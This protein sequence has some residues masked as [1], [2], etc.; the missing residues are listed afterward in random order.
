MVEFA[1]NPVAAIEGTIGPLGRDQSSIQ[2][3]FNLPGEVGNA[4]LQPETSAISENYV[5]EEAWTEDEIATIMQALDGIEELI[6]VTFVRTTD[7][8]AADLDFVKNNNVESSTG[9]SRSFLVTENGETHRESTIV[10]NHTISSLSLWRSPWSGGYEIGTYG[11]QTLLTQIGGALGLGFPYNEG[12]GSEILRS[13]SPTEPFARGQDGLNDS[14]NS[15]MASGI[16]WDVYDTVNFQSGARGTMGAW[17]IAALQNIYGANENTNSEDNVYILT[18]NFVV[19]PS[20]YK[21]IYDTGGEDWIIAGSL[22]SPGLTVFSD[23]QID[24]RAATLD[25]DGETSGGPV[26][27]TFGAGNTVEQDGFTI[28]AGSIIEN[29]QGDYGDDTL[30]GN[31]HANILIGKNGDDLFLPGLGEDTLDGGDG[32][33]EYAG[34][35]AEL[36]GDT[37]LNITDNDRIFVYG[38]QYTDADL[39]VI[40]EGGVVKLIADTGAQGERLEIILGPDIGLAPSEYRLFTSPRGADTIITFAQTDDHSNTI[41]GATPFKASGI[42]SFADADEVLYG[43]IEEAGDV[44]VFDNFDVLFD[45][46]L[47][48]VLGAEAGGGTLQNPIIE[49]YDGMGNLEFSDAGSGPGGAAR[50]I[51]PEYPDPGLL[52]DPTDRYIFVR[53]ANGETGTYTLRGVNEDD[54]TDTLPESDF[55]VLDDTVE[56]YVD[57]APL[58]AELEA[59]GDVDVV[60]VTLAEGGLYVIDAKAEANRFGSKVDTKIELY[61]LAGNLLASDQDSGEGTDAQL[62]YT[63]QTSGSHYAFITSEGTAEAQQTGEYIADLRVVDDY[64]NSFQDAFILDTAGTKIN[65]ALEFGTDVDFFGALLVEG[66]TYTIRMENSGGDQLT[67][68]D[69]FLRERGSFEFDF[70]FSPS[71]EYTATTTG[72]HYFEF[73]KEFASGVRAYTLSVSGGPDIPVATNEDDTVLGTNNSELIYGYAGDDEIRGLNGAD[74][75]NG[76]DGN[77]LIDGG[78]DDDTITG[79]AGDDIFVMR[80]G[81]GDDIITDFEKSSGS[82]D[83]DKLDITAHDIAF[84]DIGFA[85][86]AD[87]LRIGLG[88]DSVLL[89]GSNLTA[90]DVSDFI[91][92]GVAQDPRSDFNADSTDDV[93]WRRDDGAVAIWEMADAGRVGTAGLGSLS[94]RWDA[95][96]LGDVNGDGTSDIIWRRDDGA[97]AVWTLDDS[98]RSDTNGLGSLGSNWQVAGAGDFN[99]DGT[100][101]ILWHRDNGAVAVWTL[102]DG[103]RAD[104]GGMGQLNTAWQ[105]G[106]VGDFNGDGTD[107]I[108]WRRDDGSVAIWSVD[109]TAR[110]ASSGLGR[111]S[112]AWEIAATGDFD[113][114]GTDDI[115]WRRDTGAV[116]IWTLDGSEKSA[117]S[118]LGSLSLD[119]DIIGSGDYNGDGT[120][121]ILWQRDTGAVAVWT[122]EDSARSDVSGLERLPTGWEPQLLF[123]DDL[124]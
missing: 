118:G 119:W 69:P 76:G 24:L 65:G 95:A 30:I 72:L 46:T 9:S 92:G 37:I 2:V 106:G 63:A 115:L 64:G 117:T 113:G 3:Y 59:Q 103:A 53:G 100:D 17:D 88:S 11:Y 43:V 116:A 81:D 75:I 66:E 51:I 85:Q 77:D 61:D 41:A 123:G 38:V 13:L 42:S 68:Y 34:T 80:P 121:D 104:T 33:D 40:L 5:H 8:A 52:T 18:D 89:Q 110:S 4:A 102:E 78:L 48:E 36:N 26:S 7:K 107:D 57:R 14:I 58:D 22:Y 73:K 28:A 44:D 62:T 99:G 25:Y 55:L 87:G 90:L 29:A 98:A 21:T 56:I 91:G 74:T 39:S 84:S 50:V 112:N 114:D 101:D 45:G 124:G 86:E 1:Q 60:K 94:T 35:V 97:V 19:N 67:L 109:D 122:I 31:V 105:I 54:L 108:L 71:R 10:I 49:I 20:Y 32:T 83:G 96:A 111:I 120:D 6:D 12:N 47:L 23:V 15:V 70:F 82:S 79:G 93:L 16:G 27:F